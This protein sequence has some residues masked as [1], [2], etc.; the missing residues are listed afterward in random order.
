MEKLRFGGGGEYVD[1]EMAREPLERV[2]WEDGLICPH[3]VVVGAHYRVNPR[4]GSRRPVRQGVWRCRDCRKQF[5]VTVGT[6]FQGS[7][8][9]LSK[10]VT[11]I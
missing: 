9:P 10:W 11:V 2:R 4:K 6:V 5:A 3:W 1:E 8:I 7:K